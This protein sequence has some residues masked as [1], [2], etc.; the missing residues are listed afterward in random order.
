MS[1]PSDDLLYEVHVIEAPGAAWRLAAS[2]DTLESARVAAVH[3][4]QDSTTSSVRIMHVVEY[5][6][7]AV[8]EPQEA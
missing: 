7:K 3:L 4:V 2:F 8:P 5:Y 6:S 1:A